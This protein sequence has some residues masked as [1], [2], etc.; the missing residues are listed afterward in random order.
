LLIFSALSLLITILL[1]I[2]KTLFYFY[3]MS[4][5]QST[6]VSG[7]Y[8]GTEEHALQIYKKHN[9]LQELIRKITP[10]MTERLSKPFSKLVKIYMQFF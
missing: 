3:F 2:P 8:K 1:E 7:H 5:I 6:V 4:Q 9:D 10:M